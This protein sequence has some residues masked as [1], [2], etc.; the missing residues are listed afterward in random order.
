MSGLRRTIRSRRLRRSVRRFV[1][2]LPVGGGSIL[3]LARAAESGVLDHGKDHVATASGLP[4]VPPIRFRLRPHPA[5]VRGPFDEPPR[6]EHPGRVFRSIAPPAAPPPT[7]DI[8]LFVALNAEYA[9][10][11]LVP[12][13]PKK[14]SSS[15]SLHA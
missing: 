9:A 13:P 2:L 6:I 7:F 12:D 11:P 14:D 3:R 10:R 8:E 1:E 4:P 5:A 15:L